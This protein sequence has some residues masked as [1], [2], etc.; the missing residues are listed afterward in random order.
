ML[1]PINIEDVICSRPG[2]CDLRD[3]KRSLQCNKD[4]AQATTRVGTSA[5]LGNV[6]RARWSFLQS[7]GPECCKSL[8]ITTVHV[9]TQHQL[10]LSEVWWQQVCKTVF[11][12]SFAT[13]AMLQML[14]CKICTAKYH[15]CLCKWDNVTKTSWLHPPFWIPRTNIK[16]TH[17]N[18][19]YIVF[20]M[21]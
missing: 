9:Q 8:D 21:I 5:W 17:C 6:F 4:P 20:R 14:A 7:S 12:S 19:V 3:F 1:P 16:T 10:F 18:K 11:E 13:I 2:D 15:F